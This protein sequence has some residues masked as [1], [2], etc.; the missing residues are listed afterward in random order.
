MIDD[1]IVYYFGET[2]FRLVV[3][4]GTAEKDIAWFGK[5]NAEGGYGL[6]ITPRRDLAI[7]AVQGPNAREKVWQ[8]AAGRA[9]PPP[10]P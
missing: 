4:A 10:K 5:L 8:V 3:N 9:A 6:T 7:V 1:L 2:H